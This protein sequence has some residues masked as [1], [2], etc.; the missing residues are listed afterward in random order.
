MKTNQLKNLLPCLKQDWNQH[1]KSCPGN[2][3]II[4]AWFIFKLSAFLSTFLALALCL[5]SAHNHIIVFFLLS[6]LQW[7]CKGTSKYK[8]TAGHFPAR[9]QKRSTSYYCK[10]GLSTWKNN[11]YN[12]NIKSICSHDVNFINSLSCKY[13]SSLI[14]TLQFLLFWFQL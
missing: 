4:M 14:R 3:N 10:Y 9:L 6:N 8:S 7:L 2:K 5:A 13:L 11:G 1:L 12:K